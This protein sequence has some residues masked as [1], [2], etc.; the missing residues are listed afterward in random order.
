[1]NMPQ[2]VKQEADQ[3]HRVIR[4]RAATILRSLSQFL[5]FSSNYTQVSLSISRVQCSCHYLL[6]WK[7]PAVEKGKERYV[8][9]EKRVLR[10]RC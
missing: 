6:P 7:W 3:G 9:A 5:E 10:L 2:L 8:L 1:M 4:G